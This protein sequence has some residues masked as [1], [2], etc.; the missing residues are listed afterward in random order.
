MGILLNRLLIILNDSEA[1][2]T[3]YHIA[4]TLIQNF[5]ELHLL[6][7]GEVARLCSVSKSTIS[8]FIRSLGFED[9]ADFR[10]SSVFEENKYGFNLNYNQNIAEY[11]DQNGLDAYLRCIEDDI[12]D[13]RAFYDLGTIRELAHDLTVYK[14]V[15]AFGLLF[16]ELGAMDLQMKL[17]Y[18]GK[19]ILSILSDTKQD[20]YIRSADE[21]TLI[22]VY[23]NSGG[24]IERYQLS[25]FQE[26]KHYAEVRAKLVLITANKEMMSHPAVDLCVCYR[27][28]SSIQSHS[29]LYPLVND[30]IIKEYRR[31]A[32]RSKEARQP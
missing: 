4:R 7:I 17:A 29:V 16:S 1:A 10:A 19:F 32:G 9:Y 31:L 18:N 8:K 21:D 30:A 27:H 25:E 12:K 23:S 24:Y 11:I 26:A 5:Y 20:H 13:F 28:L 22:I 15:A 6:S 3:D 14:K 2:S